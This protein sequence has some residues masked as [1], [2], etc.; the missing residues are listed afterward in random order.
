MSADVVVEEVVIVEEYDGE[1]DE[2]GE[3]VLGDDGYW[4]CTIE[5]VEEIEELDSPPTE[6]KKPTL[7]DKKLT[8]IKRDR[9][10]SLHSL[11]ESL[12][13]GTSCLIEIRTQRLGRET[14]SL[15][16]SPIKAPV[17]PSKIKIPKARTPTLKRRKTGTGTLQRKEKMTKSSGT[18]KKEK[19][20]KKTLTKVVQRRRSESILSVKE[21][22]ALSKIRAKQQAATNKMALS[23]RIES[24]RQ[25]GREKIFGETL[26][27]LVLRQRGKLED[28]NNPPS[29]P[30]LVYFLAEYIRE[31]GIKT[32]GLFRECGRHSTQ[33]EKEAMIEAGVE[34]T[35]L[36]LVRSFKKNI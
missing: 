18:V 7:L 32:P 4:Y 12:R 5:E 33:L 9:T 20:K 10:Q 30:K 17:E 24:M 13:T 23:N 16:S 31:R 21:G 19:E 11:P 36:G 22:N 2:D 27:N 29:V 35:D 28:P 14:N 8:D 15:P 1:G 3:W 6:I 34:F 25:R 26:D